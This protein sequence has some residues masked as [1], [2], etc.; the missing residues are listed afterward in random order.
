MPSVLIV[1]DDLET[2]MAVEA[3]LEEAALEDIQ[4]VTDGSKAL[5]YLKDS[6][7]D[8]MMLDLMMPNTDGFGVLRALRLGDV[9]R[10]GHVIVMS[11]HANKA[12]QESVIL[13]GADQFL[14]KPFTF[15]QLEEALNNSVL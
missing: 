12:D 11:A 10:P 9:I 7:P 4:S 5:D 1:E 8:L 2:R 13:L 14:A 6:T 3:M 15:V